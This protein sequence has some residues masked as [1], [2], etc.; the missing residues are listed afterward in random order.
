[1]YEAHLGGYNSLYSVFSMDHMIWSSIMMHRLHWGTS[2]CLNLYENRTEGRV[3]FF[4]ETTP[5]ALVVL[6]FELG[7]APL[8]VL[9]ISKYFGNMVFRLIG[10]K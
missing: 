4:G 5:K 1:M 3:S 2:R 6:N 7:D 10:T 9:E 8:A